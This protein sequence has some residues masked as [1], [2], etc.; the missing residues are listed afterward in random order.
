[1]AA[2]QASLHDFERYTEPDLSKLTPAER[3]AF[4]AVVQGDIGGRE[5]ARRTNRSWGTVS[6]LLMRSREK[7]DVYQEGNV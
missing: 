2:V 5:Y 3:D 6:N 1:M 4:E 7:L